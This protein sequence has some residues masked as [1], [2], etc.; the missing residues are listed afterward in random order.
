MLCAA[1][2]RNGLFLYFSASIR[3]IHSIAEVKYDERGT[4]L[5]CMA[6]DANNDPVDVCERVKSIEAEVVVLTK[7]SSDSLSEVTCDVEHQ[8]NNVSVA[9]RA[10]LGE[11]LSGAHERLAPASLPGYPSCMEERIVG[12]GRR[13]TSERRQLCVRAVWPAYAPLPEDEYDFRTSRASVEGL[14]GGVRLSLT[15]AEYETAEKANC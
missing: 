5:P 9:L 15:L 1:L 3:H 10:R 11:G 13:L 8:A 14:E 7:E 2:G 4:L 12:D 6:R